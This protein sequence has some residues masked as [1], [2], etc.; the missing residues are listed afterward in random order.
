M[1]RKSWQR[2]QIQDSCEE[3][4]GT[5]GAQS[6]AL[7]TIRSLCKGSQAMDLSD[8]KPGDW[9]LLGA[10]RANA[11]FAYRGKRQDLVRLQ[12]SAVFFEANDGDQKLYEPFA[13]T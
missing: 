2:N 3:Y 5:C 7:R 6:A 8:T 9:V 13:T 1:H 11:V 10:G 4:L 12:S